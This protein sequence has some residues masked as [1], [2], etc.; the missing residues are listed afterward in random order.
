M[1]EIILD[2]PDGLSII[3]KVFIRGRQRCQESE[4]ELPG[5]KQRLK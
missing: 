2:Y 3:K 4:K 5:W 1:E